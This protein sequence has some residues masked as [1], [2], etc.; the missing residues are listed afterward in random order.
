M[1]M[2][3]STTTTS[4]LI[5]IRLDQVCA[6]PNVTPIFSFGGAPST[7]PPWRSQPRRS[8][9]TN[10]RTASADSSDGF[11]CR[12]VVNLSRSDLPRHMEPISTYRDDSDRGHAFHRPEHP[13]KVHSR[14]PIH[15]ARPCRSDRPRIRSQGMKLTVAI[16][17]TDTS[18]TVLEQLA[19]EVPFPEHV[20]QAGRAHTARL[21][22]ESDRNLQLVVLRW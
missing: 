7:P 5:N 15:R 21:I 18:Q 8:I 16:Y 14:S 9:I 11:Q 3:G 2:Y 6:M 10:Y 19:L 17:L 12:P 13:R 4:R 20:V 22:L 1:T